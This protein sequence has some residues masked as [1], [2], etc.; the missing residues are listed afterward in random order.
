MCLIPAHF[1]KLTCAKAR[2]LRTELH[3]ASL[4]GRFIAEYLPRI[5]ALVDALAFVGDHVPSQQHIDVILGLSQEFSPVIYAI[6]SKFRMVQLRRCFWLMRCVF[7]SSRKL[8]ALIQCRL[9]SHL[10]LLRVTCLY[11]KLCL[12][13]LNLLLQ[14]LAILIQVVAVEEDVL[15]IFSVRSVL[16]LGTLHS[17]VTIGS[18]NSFNLLYLVSVMVKFAEM[19]SMSFQISSSFHQLKPVPPPVLIL[20]LVLA[21]V[22][23]PLLMYLNIYLVL[24]NSI[25]T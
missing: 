10:H 2:Q 16:S 1:Q 25:G 14:V 8:Q 15:A 21:L 4:E 20:I 23:S 6:E 24:L 11:P 7:K 18:I 13:L 19:A 22:Y 5:K 17:I 3:S 9:I 12:P